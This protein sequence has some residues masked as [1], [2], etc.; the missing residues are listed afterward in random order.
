MTSKINVTDNE[1]GNLEKLQPRKM[2]QLQT[3]S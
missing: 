3:I 1:L 2:R